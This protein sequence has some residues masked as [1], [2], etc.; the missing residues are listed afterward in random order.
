MLKKCL[1]NLTKEELV[2]EIRQLA[3]R[4]KQVDQYYKARMESHKT[5]AILEAYKK[6][7]GHEFFT[8]GGG[9][10]PLN[11]RAARKVVL[12]FAKIQANTTHQIDLELFYVEQGVKFTNAFGDID[13]GFYMSVESM[14]ERALK[15]VQKHHM[16]A[17]F[18]WR[19]AKIRKDTRELGWGFGDNIEYLYDEYFSKRKS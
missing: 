6:R 1:E 14:F 3:K 12:D 10:G 15:N 8:R 13:E 2:E 17:A 16:E 4:F 18:I 9:P 5:G 11:L 7:V 19:A